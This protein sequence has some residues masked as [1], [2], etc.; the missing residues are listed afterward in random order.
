MH[1]PGAFKGILIEGGGQFPP[2][3]T[4][5][6]LVFVGLFYDNTLYLQGKQYYFFWGGGAFNELEIAMPPSQKILFSLWL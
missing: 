1:N 3:R 5:T 4:E 6:Y 2:I